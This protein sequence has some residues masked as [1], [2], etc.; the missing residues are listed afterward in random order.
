MNDMLKIVKETDK[1]GFNKLTTHITQSWQWGEF[2]LKTPN[3][4]KV[5][6][7]SSGTKV[8]QIFFHRV[9]HLPWT[10]AYLPRSLSPNKS[11]LEEIKTLCQQERALFLKL[12]PLTSVSGIPS[13]PLEVNQ[14]LVSSSVLPRHTI[15]IDLTKTEEQML[16]EMHEKTRYNIRL[17]EKKGVRIS[18]GE[19][20]E[21]FIELLEKTEKR[22]GFYSHPAGY[23]KTLWEILRPAKM[24]YIL[25]ADLPDGAS[26]KSGSTAAIMLLRH[27]EILYYAYGGSD[28]DYRDMMA[29]HL[30]HWEAI[31]LGKKLGCKVYDLWGSYKDKPEKSDPWW[32]IYRFK[33]GFG[34]QEITFPPTV[35]VPLS[36]LYSLYL[37]AEK[38]RW[39]LPR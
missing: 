15:Y 9:P 22:Q 39:L 8:F 7:L 19:N 3:V 6:R 35:D 29:P 25:S 26:A 36:P 33:K 13:P 1:D 30:L 37:L 17:A 28:P 34:G 12:E 16:A 4:K 21:N 11:E 5:L 38:F 14:H 10:I 32:G 27:R 18:E 31:K 2:R 24:V 23:Y 20:L